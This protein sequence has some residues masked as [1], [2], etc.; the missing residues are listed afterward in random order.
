MLYD[1][2][3]PLSS[4]GEEVNK[5]VAELERSISGYKEEYAVLISQAQAI[6]SGLASV[7]AKVCAALP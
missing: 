4:Q 7:E 5:L 1:T 6:K 2:P 3:S